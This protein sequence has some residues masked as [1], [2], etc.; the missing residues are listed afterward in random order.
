MRRV[1][2]LVCA[3][4]TLIGCSADQGS[5]EELC[6]AWKAVPDAA[7]LFAGFDPSDAPRALQ[8]LTAG[9]VV[10]RE[11]RSAAPP[12]PRKDLDVEIAYFDALIDG[13]AELDGS[14]AEQAARLVDEI[15]AE[16]PAVAEAAARLV[17]FSE[18]SCTAP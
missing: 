1:A 18:E 4:S 15:T 10:L 11:L 2:A 8:Q 5:V 3:V 13:L 7:G 9:R 16:H 12:Q 17:S 6:A 14:D